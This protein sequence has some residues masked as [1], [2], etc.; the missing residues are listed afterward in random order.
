MNF[1]DDIPKGIVSCLTCNDKFYAAGSFS[2]VIGLYDVNTMENIAMLQGHQ[3]GITH[4]LLSPDGTQLY[5]GAR[6]VTIFG[7]SK[8]KFKQE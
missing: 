1:T 8:S 5:S 4:L 2:R 3:G 7:Y 6:K